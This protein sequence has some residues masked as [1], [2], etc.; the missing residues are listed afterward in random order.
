MEKRDIEFMAWN[1]YVDR[2]FKELH[3]GISKVPA[4]LTKFKN[5]ALLYWAEKWSSRFGEWIYDELFGYVWR[6]ADERFAF[7]QRP[8]FHASFA[9][10]NG[11]L[12]LI[13]QEPWGWVPA[14]M[15]TWVWLK[16]G[17][18]W[19]P[20]DWFHNGIVDFNDTY[21]FPTLGYYWSLYQVASPPGRRS[22]DA[23]RVL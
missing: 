20:G 17:W 12:F 14:H 18:T 15:G 23:I 21:M 11:E 4:N 7:S 9:R 10:V 16:R 1:E 19:I 22:R 6:P 3:Y 8:F 2:H 5:Q 13:P